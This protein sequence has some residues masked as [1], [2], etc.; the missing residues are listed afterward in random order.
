MTPERRAEIADQIGVADDPTLRAHAR[1]LLAEIERL[2]A[3]SPRKHRI[4]VT[5]REEQDPSALMRA[6]GKTWLCFCGDTETA[7][8]AAV[9][10]LALAHHMGALKHDREIARAAVADLLVLVAEL[11]GAIQDVCGWRGWVAHELH[12]RVAA[13]L[14]KHGSGT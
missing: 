6:L 1:E 10:C 12:G 2:E 5:R 14:A 4:D 9:E 11:Y 7:G 3:D 13:A 8:L